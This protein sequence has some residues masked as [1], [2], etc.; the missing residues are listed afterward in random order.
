MLMHAL[1][2]TL[3]ICIHVHK[4]YAYV[5]LVFPLAVYASVYT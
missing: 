3:K 4:T 5:A 2:L 1:I